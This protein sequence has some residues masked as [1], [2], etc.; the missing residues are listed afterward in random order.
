MDIIIFAA[1]AGFILYRLYN[2]LGKDVG[3]KPGEVLEPVADTPVSR[4]TANKHVV[5]ETLSSQLQDI[6]KVDPQ[7]DQSEF[8]DGATNAFGMIL[9]AFNKGDKKTL[10]SLLDSKL[11]T[12]FEKAITTR[13]KNKEIW[14][15]TLIRVQSAEITDLYV[16]KQSLMFATVKF[17]SDQILVT[18]DKNGTVIEGDHDQIEVLTDN[19]TFTRDA[20]SSDPN[21]LLFKTAQVE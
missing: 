20:N 14:D 9:E 10:K 21:W 6:K 4:K 11:Y 17:V 12:I 19:W 16:E 5:S 3:L 15:N 8:L 7:F 1:I 2:V 18:T 13:E